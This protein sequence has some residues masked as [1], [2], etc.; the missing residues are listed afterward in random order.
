MHLVVGPHALVDAAIGPD[1][2]AL[3]LYPVLHK[4]PLILVPICPREDA[5]PVLSSVDVAANELAA[6]GPALHPAP[7]LQVVLPEAAVLRP[8]LVVDEADP[9]RLIVLPLALIHLAVLVDE[10][11]I[12]VRLVVLPV[13][14]EHAT[15]WVDLETAPVARVA[16]LA[17]LA[18]VDRAVFYLGRC[19]CLALVEAHRALSLFAVILQGSVLQ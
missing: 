17:P 19:S 9:V 1:L 7:V 15:V 6:V 18:Y 5:M 10:S 13:P 2:A 8:M 14:L 3:S 16:V 4:L 12:V 11:T